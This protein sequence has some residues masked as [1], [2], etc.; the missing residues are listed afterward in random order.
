MT[1]VNKA[2]KTGSQTTRK[3]QN[4]LDTCDA[5]CSSLL[6]SLR[7]CSTMLTNDCKQGGGLHIV[8]A[9]TGPLGLDDWLPIWLDVSETCAHTPGSRQSIGHGSMPVQCATDRHGSCASTLFL[10]DCVDFESRWINGGVRFY[11]EA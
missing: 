9:Y 6:L 7:N 1:G 11:G 5:H 8:A 4:S 3:L 10:L 2:M